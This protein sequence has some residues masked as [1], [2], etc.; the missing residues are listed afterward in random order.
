MNSFRILGDLYSYK[1]LQIDLIQQHWTLLILTPGGSS[2]TDINVRTIAAEVYLGNLLKLYLKPRARQILRHRP[3][4]TQN[5]SSWQLGFKSHDPKPFR[6]GHKRVTNL[7]QL[8]RCETD[9][10]SLHGSRVNLN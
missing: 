4:A 5:P 7:E 3:N 6:V 9:T 1:S 10:F 2:C 8:N